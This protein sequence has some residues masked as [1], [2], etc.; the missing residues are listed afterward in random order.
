MCN[1][2]ATEFHKSLV[3]MLENDITDVLYETFCDEID[4]FGEKKVRTSS[5]RQGRSS[6]PLGA[7]SLLTAVCAAGAHR[8]W[9]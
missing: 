7:T 2:N 6:I 5:R 9:I 1:R 3:W 8:W 4:E